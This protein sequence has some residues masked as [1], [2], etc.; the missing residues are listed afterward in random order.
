[1]S[2]DGVE[3]QHLSLPWGWLCED[4]AKI[5]V[6]EALV[7]EECFRYESNPHLHHKLAEKLW[8]STHRGRGGNS[9]KLREASELR[10]ANEALSR[11]READSELAESSSRW[12]FKASE[13]LG[14][15]PEESEV[16]TRCRNEVMISNA[17]ADGGFG[18]Y[19]G[20]ALYPH[21]FSLNISS[22]IEWYS[23]RGV[24]VHVVMS[25]RDPSI[26]H[27]GKMRDHCHLDGPGQKEGQVAIDL[28]QEAL[29]KAGTR[30][31]VIVSSY[32]ALMTFKEAHLF[33]LYREL[34]IESTYIPSFHGGNTKY[35]TRA[36][37]SNGTTHERPE[38]SDGHKSTLAPAEFVVPER[39][40]VVVGTGSLFLADSLA[41]ATGAVDELA[42][43][44]KNHFFRTSRD[45]KLAVQH[46]SMPVGRMCNAGEGPV[47]V[48]QFLLPQ[49]CS[50]NT[51]LAES[52]RDRLEV[53]LESV[54][55]PSRFFVNLT[56]HL[57]F[58]L[59]LGAET[60]VVLVARDNDIV[61]KERLRDCPVEAITQDDNERAITI[62]KE[63]Y[64]RQT[65]YEEKYPIR[66]RRKQRTGRVGRVIFAYYEGFML[67]NRIYLFDLYRQL[68]IDSS[69]APEFMDE[70]AKYISDPP[71][72]KIANEGGSDASMRHKK[73]L[74]RT[75][76][77]RNRRNRRFHG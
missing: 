42:G 31:R 5:N 35:I 1:M 73:G 62:M 29:S 68:G 12:T 20:M 77:A 60:S 4:D 27:L 64:E 65:L 53:D 51:T 37:G 43:T 36:L 54:T 40:I 48:V 56:S 15:S 38:P 34:G 8:Y 75:Y 58:W 44:H 74:V 9:S 23:S 3:I 46:M 63:V 10:A 69:H 32:E 17:T 16:I 14:T 59:K 52:C 25:I 30:G 21:R 71:S 2:P 57:E 39:L 11:N 66:I 7:P 33:G 41:V 6:V 76:D 70:N 19:E 47:E 28:M 26:S 55:Y 67:L 45:G 24:E 49:V 61:L 13:H 72:A 18:Q 22:H 50:L